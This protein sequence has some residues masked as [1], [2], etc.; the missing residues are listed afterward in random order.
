MPLPIAEFVMGQLDL[1]GRHPTALSQPTHFP[2]LPHRQ[3]Y[4]F[5]RDFEPGKRHFFVVGFRYGAD[6]QSLWILEIGLLV[7]ENWWSKNGGQG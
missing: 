4:F 5:D 1:L 3:L 7:A 2:Y 6:E